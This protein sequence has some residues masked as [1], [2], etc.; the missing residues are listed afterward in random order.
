MAGTEL[1]R[2]SRKEL[3]ELLVLQSKEND[4]LKKRLSEVEA[5]L[6]DRQILLEQAGTIA[7]ASLQL[8]Q[9]FEAAQR[10]ADQYLVNVR[11]MSGRQEQICRQMEKESE[12]KAEQMLAQMQEHC[13]ML[14]EETKEKC[15]LMLHETV[16]KTE[17]IEYVL[18]AVHQG[19]HTIIG[20]RFDLPEALGSCE[21]DTDLP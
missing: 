19:A 12:K 6:E 7:D 14:E 9:V 3:L 4:R 2:M 20:E 13:R 10:A 16:K 18:Q 11:A 15:D 17:Y 1:Q 21:E 8:N 5:M